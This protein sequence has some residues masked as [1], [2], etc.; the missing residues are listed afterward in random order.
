MLLGRSTMLMYDKLY[1]DPGLPLRQ[2]RGRI[3]M[4]RYRSQFRRGQRFAD[5]RQLR[6][7]HGVYVKARYVAYSESH[8]AS[9]MTHMKGVKEMRQKCVNR[10]AAMFTMT[11]SGALTPQGKGPGVADRFGDA[12]VD[13]VADHLGLGAWVRV[14]PCTARGSSTALWTG[15]ALGAYGAA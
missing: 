9:S 10:L 8:D 7:I 14:S 11:S 1:R 15:D 12:A 3:E 2:D 4:R 13:D 5:G 6:S